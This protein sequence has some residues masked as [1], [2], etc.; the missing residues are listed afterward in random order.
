VNGNGSRRGRPR[1][2]DVLTPA[3]WRTVDA[4]RHGMST[5]H[6]ARLRGVSPDAVKFHV[7]NALAKLGL[8]DR[9]ELRKWRGVPSDSALRKG[10]PA[11]EAGARLELGPLGQISRHVRDFD[12]AVDWYGKTLGLEHLYT[13]GRLAFYDCGGVRLMISPPESGAQPGTPSL[14]YFRVPDIQHAYDELT[15]RGV[16]F[17]GAPHLIHRHANGVEEWMAFFDD[18]DGN[19]LA[20]MSQV[21]PRQG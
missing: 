11:M 9:A 17:S 18:P 13:F 7:A 10:P 21:E 8:A 1:H 20:I 16:V 14:L 15:A 12:A 3:E 5:R 4:V 2:P 6:I 19:P